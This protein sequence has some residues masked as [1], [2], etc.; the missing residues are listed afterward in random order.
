MKKPAKS[1]QKWSAKEVLGHLCD[2]AMNNYSRFIRL[3]HTDN[4][5]YVESYKQD[6]WVELGNYQNRDWQN[7]I[8]LWVSLNK[9]MISVI[10]HAPESTWQHELILGNDTSTFAVL[11][12]D[13]IGHMKHHFGQLGA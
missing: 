10:E 13:Y 3:Q 12:Q 8:Q 7:I 1:P 6:A 9:A 2:S 11:I 4:T 5:F